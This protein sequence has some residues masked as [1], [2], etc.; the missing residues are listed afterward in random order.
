MRIDPKTWEVDY[1]FP[2]TRLPDISQRLHGIAY[3]NGFIWQVN[4]RQKPGTS[5]YEG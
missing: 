2:A 5:D 3:D 1:M 4:G